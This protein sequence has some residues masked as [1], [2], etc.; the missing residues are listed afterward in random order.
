MENPNLDITIYSSPG[1][2]YCEQAKELCDRVAQ[3]PKILTVGQDISAKDF[4][5]K[6]PNVNAYPH[7]IVEGKVI[8]G[9]VEFAKLVIKE[10]LMTVKINGKPTG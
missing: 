8:G 3:K 2:F 1:C 4:S 7:I 10:G 6:F 9:L 5:I